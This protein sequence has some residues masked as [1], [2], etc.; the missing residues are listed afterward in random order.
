MKHSLNNKL[1]SITAGALLITA[2]GLATTGCEN[3][4]GNRT[5]QSTGIGAAGGAAAG[6]IILEDN[7]LLGALLGGL[8]G[9][10]GGYLIGTQTDWFEDDDSGRTREQAEEAARDAQYNPATA[11]EARNATTADINSDGFVTLDEVVAMSDAGFSDDEMINRLRATN[12]VFDLNEDQRQFLHDNGVSWNVINRMVEIRANT[13]NQLIN[14]GE[15]RNR[16]MGR[17]VIGRDAS[18]D[19][20]EVN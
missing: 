9:A 14:Q 11:A 6:A 3:L 1:T 19:V 18:E 5:E 17:E 2:T 15:Q 4:P 13:R 16:D 8:L 7:R 12:Q 20:R 10:G